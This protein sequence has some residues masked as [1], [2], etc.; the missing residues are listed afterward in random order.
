MSDSDHFHMPLF[1]PGTAV[2]WHGQPETVSHVI[3]RRGGLFVYLVGHEAPV[4]A[5]RLALTP[6]RFTA[7]RVE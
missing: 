2:A 7:L 5:E 6:S 3:L 4:A 1:R